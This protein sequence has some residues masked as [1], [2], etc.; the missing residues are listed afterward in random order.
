MKILNKVVEHTLLILNFIFWNFFFKKFEYGAKVS[1]FANI[2]GYKHIAIKNG[3]RILRGVIITCKN[4]NNFESLS[5]GKNTVISQYCV[6][7][8]GHE[9]ITIGDNCSIQQ[10]CKLMDGISIGNWTRVAS[11]CVIVGSNH[12]FNNKKQIIKKQGNIFKRINIGNDVWI[13]SNS[14]ILC[15]VSLGDGAVVGASSLVNNDVES[16]SVVVGNPIRIIKK[17]Q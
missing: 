7:N 14:V 6:I 10:F 12:K 9:S 11:G 5:I 16:C 13:G 4:N 8:P 1:L 15:G 3:S 2:V 17:R